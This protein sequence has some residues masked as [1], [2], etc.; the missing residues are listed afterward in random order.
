MRNNPSLQYKSNLQHSYYL[1]ALGREPGRVCPLS[2]SHIVV[3][4]SSFRMGL[5]KVRRGSLAETSRPPTSRFA[6]AL[7]YRRGAL[8]GVVQLPNFD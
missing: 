8:G 3:S 6:P 4:W 1:R 5:A 2:S 7:S